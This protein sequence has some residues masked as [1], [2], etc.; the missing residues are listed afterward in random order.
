MYWI[1]SYDELDATV[2]TKIQDSGIWGIARDKSSHHSGE[3]DRPQ[4]KN[5]SRSSLTRGCNKTGPSNPP[6]SR[7]FLSS[8]SEVRKGY[9]PSLGHPCDHF[10]PPRTG[11]W[12]KFES[13]LWF[14]FSVHVAV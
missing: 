7:P 4:D 8:E 2:T 11:T 12:S 5:D 1:D 6:V 14:L 10:P 3:E 13:F 9:L